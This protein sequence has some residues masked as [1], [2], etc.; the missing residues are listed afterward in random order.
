MFKIF[1]LL[2]IF[3]LFNNCSLENKKLSLKKIS[4]SKSKSISDL[5]FDYNLTFDQFKKNAVEYGML[6]NYPILDE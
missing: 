6:S 1:F 2:F 4:N 3:F 5:K